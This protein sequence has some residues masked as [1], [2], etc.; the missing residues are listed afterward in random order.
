MQHHKKPVH[1]FTIFP[2]PSKTNAYL[3]SHWGLKPVPPNTEIPSN[4]LPKGIVSFWHVPDCQS[5]P[6]GYICIMWG[7]LVVLL[8]SQRPPSDRPPTP[9]SEEKP[10]LRFTSLWPGIDFSSPRA[11]WDI[12]HEICVISL[13][14]VCRSGCV[15]VTCPPAASM[16]KQNLGGNKTLHWA[17][18][19]Q[20]QELRVSYMKTDKDHVFKM[21][22]ILTPV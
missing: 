12:N 19:L 14:K 17:I 6:K 2:F 8:Y 7:F 18:M 16:S 22:H 21:I 4:F 1:L 10:A 11:N 13:L 15:E 9:P 20:L 3:V 5:P